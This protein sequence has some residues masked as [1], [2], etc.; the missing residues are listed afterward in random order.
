MG[1]DKKSTI[2]GGLSIHGV[3]NVIL[4]NINLQ[5]HIPIQHQVIALISA[6]A[7]LMFG[8]IM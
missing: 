4:Y 3:K 6:V 8:F 7:Q 5:V 2:Y 1:K